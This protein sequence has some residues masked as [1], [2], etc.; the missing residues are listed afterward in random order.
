MRSSV[1]AELLDK[2]L[3][4]YAR[5]T[6]K[7]A[8]EVAGVDPATMSRLACRARVECGHT[9]PYRPGVAAY[10][11]GCRCDVCVPL[12]EPFV[13]ALADYLNG[14]A[15]MED[16]GER[17]GLTRER[18]RQAFDRLCGGPGEAFRQQRA[19]R[20]EREA[21]AQA[22]AD[23]D[24][25]ARAE[26]EGVTCRT[27]GRPHARERRGNWHNT[28]SSECS[29]LWPEVRYLLPKYQKEHQRHAARWKVNHPDEVAAAEVRAAK[30]V[31]SGDGPDYED[32]RWSSRER[33]RWLVPGS[34]RFDIAVRA[35]REGWPTFVTWPQDIQDQIREHVE[36]QPDGDTEPVP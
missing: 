15:S 33:T 18:I 35:Y 27:C 24:R 31:L 34:R 12:A 4:V 7:A 1:R 13:D 3:A 11:A 19:R 30:R 6:C 28:C 29:E 32:S 23:R 16:V 17:L 14:A 10:A 5:S 36:G 8:A 26:R 22:E 21:R 9:V 20:D 2:A 25:V